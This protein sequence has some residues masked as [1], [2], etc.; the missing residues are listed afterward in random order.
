MYYLIL[1]LGII[2]GYL[3]GSV[4]Y[5]RIFSR[6]GKGVDITK[7]GNGNPG[8]SNVMR[9]V[10]KLWGS[11]TLLGDSL[12]GVLPMILFKYLFLS[13][14]S[15]FSI[16]MP[17]SGAG[18]VVVALIGLAAIYGHAY[19]VFYRFK[20]G[21]SLGVLFG[22]WWFLLYPQFL[23]CVALSYIIVKLFLPNKKYP[24]GRMTPVVF[25]VM[26]PLFILAESLFISEWHPFHVNSVLF[27]HIG[28]GN[29]FLSLNGGGWLLVVSFFV[30]ALSVIPINSSLLKNE[31]L[32]REKKD[33]RN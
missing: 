31:V 1:V 8:T 22:C 11:F 2:V 13:E 25:V 15:I 23:I 27:D 7:V 9:E 16:S 4:S 32:K 12:K 21:G 10:G 5:A 19:P 26:T 24:M 3:S 6:I 14:T 17:F 29:H 18:Y 33:G 30:F 20:G 28:W